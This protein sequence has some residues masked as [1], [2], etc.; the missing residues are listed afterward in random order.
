MHATPPIEAVAKVSSWQEIGG[1]VGRFALARSL[2]VGIVS[3]RS[4][5]RVF[6][7]P[8]LMFVPL[9]FWWIGRRCPQPD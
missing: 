7:I 3:R 2:A 5:L 9:L 8:A 4:L 6:Q 1:L